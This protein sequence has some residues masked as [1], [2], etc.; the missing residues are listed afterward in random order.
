MALMPPIVRRSPTLAANE[1]V[2][3]RI[4][5][6]RPVIHLAFGEAGLPAHPALLSRLAQ[7]A[8]AQ[9]YPPVAGTAALRNAA[10]GYFARRS[11]PTEPETIMVGPGSKPL[12]YALMLALDGDLV[13][14]VP[15]W[16]S[17][18][19]Q[20]N[21]AGKK[22]VRVPIPAEA[23]GVPDPDLLEDAL[24]GARRAGARPGILLLTAPD[25]PTGSVA[26]RGLVARVCAIARSEGLFLISDEIYRDLAFEP[27]S[28]VSPAEL[29]PE[30]TVVTGG[31]S[32][33]LSVGGW[34]LG[35]ARMPQ[36]TFGAALAGRLADLGSEIWSGTAA[37]IQ[38]AAA[39]AL[40]EPPEL[41]DYVGQ[42][43]RLHAAVAR[44]L[45]D[46]L[47]EAGAR[48]RSPQGAFYLYPELTAP[49]LG[50]AAELAETLLNEYDIAV[51][52]GDAFGDDPAALRFR[53]ASSLLYGSEDDQ[54]WQ[55]LE[56]AEPA[57]LP[58]I[59]AA[60]DR[61]GTA[62]RALGA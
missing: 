52:P 48:C 60:L 33:S 22:V 54:R 2:R 7:A 28:F 47:L 53:A 14:P 34:R 50:S 38:Q 43:R 36:N 31:L 42:G 16:V 17:Y 58:W 57:Q 62:I 41:R 12:L 25:N 45:F 44:A 11:L 30:G 51:L 4:A 40:G 3:A 26:S 56:S 8:G 55:A 27:G 19:P 21:L 10:A 9:N 32:K 5:E 35:F 46:V 49:R 37:P 1:R 24:A 61:I 23:G 15:S 18:E 20:A 6:G 59:A 39:W 13:L 29:F